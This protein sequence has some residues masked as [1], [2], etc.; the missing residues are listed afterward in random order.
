MA[1]WP[2]LSCSSPRGL[3]HGTWLGHQ[4]RFAVSVP[5]RVIKGFSDD[6]LTKM[7]SKSGEAQS[8]FDT[9]VRL[10]FKLDSAKWLPSDVKEKMRVL[11]KNRI[12]KAGDFSVSNEETSSQ[13]ENEERAIRLI[14]KFVREAEQELKSDGWE[15]NKL[16]HKDYVV[17]KFKKEGREKELE[18]REQAIKDSKKR[19]KEKTRSKKD[20]KYW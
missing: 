8:M 5:Q 20:S 17:M 13:K 15:A 6:A 4:L 11:H 2:L 7:V 16:S 18:K 1:A 3:L 19:N 10:S 9:R 12:T 14:E